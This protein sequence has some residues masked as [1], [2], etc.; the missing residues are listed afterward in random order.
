[1]RRARVHQRAEH[2]LPPSRAAGFPAIQNLLDLLALQPV[3]TAAQIA[4]DDGKVHRF[5]K[6]SA[7]GFG[8][9]GQRAVQEQIALFV[10]QLW[11]HG[12]QPPAVEQ[13]HEEGFQNVVAVMPQHDRRAALLAGNPVQI[14]APQPRAQRTEGAPGRDLVHHDGIGVCIFDAVGDLHPG[15]KFGQDGGRK[16]RLALIQIAGQQI[17]RQQPAPLQV[18]QH[19]QQ[20]IAVFAAGQADQPA[21][22]ALDH[23]I[24]FKGLAHVADQPLAQLLE[25]G[26]V[27]CAA[28]DRRQIVGFVEH[29]LSFASACIRW[30]SGCV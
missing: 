10:D 25:L 23:A 13:V 4:G 20:R 26:G 30:P 14:A 17:H 9:K 27:R 11:R 19:S 21:R 6:A 18:L 2:H 5:G 3:L 29:G 12:G 28:Q 1:M 7:I 15:Q 24:G 8:D 22:P 16:V